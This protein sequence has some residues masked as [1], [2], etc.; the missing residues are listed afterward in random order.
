LALA[1]WAKFTDE[2]AAVKA[3]P[4]QYL[5]S[6]EERFGPLDSNA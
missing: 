4:C 5:L 1:W 3:K 2:E 6:L